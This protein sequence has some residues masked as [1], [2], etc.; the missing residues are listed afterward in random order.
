[1][2]DPVLSTLDGVT[3]LGGGRITRETFFDILK[4]APRL[5]AADGAARVALEFG[6][7]PE[8]VIGDFD[9]ID[10]Q[11]RALLSDDL[12]HHIAE[13]DSTDFEKCLTR[14]DAP[15]IIG[16]GFMGARID[17]ELAVYNA[18]VRNPHKRCIIVGEYDICVH[19]PRHLKL[20]VGAGTRFSLFPLRPVVGHSKG[21]RWPIMGVPFAPG[22]R[23]GTSNEASADVVELT[24]EGDG[25]LLILPRSALP[26]LLEALG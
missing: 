16:V 5:V 12:L 17:H 26:V 4:R 13:Q 1:M 10:P 3:L 2:I 19:A 14:V 22:G 8:A 11:T 18:L 25:M 24:F 15:L 7:T 9:S 6:I 23:I 20:D 21:L